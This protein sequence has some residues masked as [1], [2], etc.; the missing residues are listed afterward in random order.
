VPPL[1]VN[2]EYHVDTLKNSGGSG[3][4]FRLTFGIPFEGR[5]FITNGSELV[6]LKY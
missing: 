4:K 6:P 3:S 5:L 2:S 1:D